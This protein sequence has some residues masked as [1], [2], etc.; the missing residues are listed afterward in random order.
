MEGDFDK[1]L[2]SCMFFLSKVDKLNFKAYG[3]DYLFSLMGVQLD[4]TILRV[5]TRFSNPELHIFRFGPILKELCPIL[6]EFKA[7]LGGPKRSKVIYLIILDGYMNY[8]AS[9]IR[10]YRDRQFPMLRGSLIRLSRLHYAFS[11][12]ISKEYMSFRCQALSFYMF[13][14]YLL[15]TNLKYDDRQ[16]LSLLILLKLGG[17]SSLWFLGRLLIDLTWF[18]KIQLMLLQE[19]LSSFKCGFW[20][21]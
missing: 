7:L 14:H 5:A 4:E 9:L 12:V 2:S 1:L 3:L 15:F 19:V 6:D 11:D 20:T 8:M 13:T 21:T 17:T 16:I 18:I 10:V